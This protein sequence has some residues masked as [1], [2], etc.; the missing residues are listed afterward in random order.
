[1][2]KCYCGSEKTFA[3]CCERFHLGIAKPTT[4]KEL[5]RSRYSAYVVANIEYLIKT[6]H[7]STRKFHDAESIEQ[8]AKLNIWQKL[9]VV[10]IKN[11]TAR[12]NEG[13]VEFRAYFI[14]SEGKSQVHHEVSNFKKELGKW[15]FVSGEVLS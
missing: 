15:F 8:F 11:G 3:E 7:P 12:D 13:I 10:S 1:M 2:T 6:T 14:N 5:M 9:E 4:A